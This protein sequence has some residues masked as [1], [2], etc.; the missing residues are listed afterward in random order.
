MARI[1][2]PQYGASGASPVVLNPVSA[3]SMISPDPL[4]HG[5]E[6]QRVT[7]PVLETRLK[8]V[9][10]SFSVSDAGLF[11]TLLRHR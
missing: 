9:V 3:T 11:L 4:K 7:V 8:G 5:I 6:L 10:V 1:Q 2:R